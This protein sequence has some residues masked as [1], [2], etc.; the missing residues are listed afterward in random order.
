MVRI[1]VKIS[2]DDLK[3]I[4]EAYREANK[5]SKIS[6]DPS[7]IKN[8]NSIVSANSDNNAAVLDSKQC[9]DLMN[10]LLKQDKKQ[11]KYFAP[12]ELKIVVTEIKKLLPNNF[13]I[14]ISMLH[15]PFPDKALEI[16][17]ENYPKI[18]ELDAGRLN[19]IV[20]VASRSLDNKNIY[21]F[22]KALK[23]KEL[24]NDPE[25][26][27]REGCSQSSYFQKGYS[28]AVYCCNDGLYEIKNGDAELIATFS[29]L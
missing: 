4:L 16:T 6:V 8:I 3:L 23:L 27:I 17:Y 12:A 25:L 19:L 26:E 7:L 20:K 14:L 18:F 21:G 11:L 15:F 9:F 5:A 2:I 29:A 24:I 13:Y 10:A 22:N 28:P 1:V